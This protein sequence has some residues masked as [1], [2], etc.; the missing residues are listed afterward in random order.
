MESSSEPRDMTRELEPPLSHRPPPLPERVR[1][2][3]CSRDR[4]WLEGHHKSSLHAF[5]SANPPFPAGRAGVP[6]ESVPLKTR[7]E[8]ERPPIGTRA[9]VV[10]NNDRA[11]EC[12][13]DCSSTVVL[14][15]A[16]SIAA[17]CKSRA[18]GVSASPP[19]GV[20]IGGWVI[21]EGGSP[22][23]HPAD[24]APVGAG[25]SRRGCRSSWFPR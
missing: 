8:P 23:A 18:G 9:W 20:R 1:V 22:G 2:A 17:P 10:R 14:P 11:S 12:L 4:G 13:T 5:V 3:S 15:S 6:A 25:P 24:C 7:R 19:S 16:R 21:I